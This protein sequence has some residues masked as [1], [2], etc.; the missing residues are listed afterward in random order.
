MNIE[1]WIQ[2]H[3]ILTI[4]ALAWILVWKGLALYKSASLQHKYWFVFILIVNTFGLL[5]MYYL[6]VVARRYKV[7]VV[8]N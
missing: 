2:E 7:E 3:P 1:T 8:E 4:L 6:F 5:E